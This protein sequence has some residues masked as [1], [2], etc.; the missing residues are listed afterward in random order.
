LVN[1]TA[2]DGLPS[3]ISTFASINSSGPKTGFLLS[4]EH[5]KKFYVVQGV[6]QHY[7][8]Q[9][10]LVASSTVPRCRYNVKFVE[11]NFEVQHAVDNTTTL[12]VLVVNPGVFQR[13]MLATQL[14]SFLATRP[15]FLK[16]VVRKLYGK[17]SF[18]LQ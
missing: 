14:I 6:Y 7:Y 9:G 15:V 3:C 5:W 17:F 2:E 12:P 16:V 13:T 11:K 1:P 18:L 8:G 4:T 10:G